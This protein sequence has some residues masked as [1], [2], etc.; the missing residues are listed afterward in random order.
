VIP[1][2][3]DTSAVVPMPRDNQWAREHGLDKSFVVMHSGNVGHS[4]NLGALVR[5]STLLRD[6]DD[7]TIAIIGTGA[8]HA[9][10]VEQ[11]Q[12]LGADAVRFFA[13][14]P[15]AIVSQSLSAADVHYVGLGPGLAG[16]VVPSRVYGI[17]AVGRPV[18]VSAD[19]ES[20]TARLVSEVGCGFVLPP[21]RPD[22]L[23]RLIRELRGGI[24]DLQGM[25]E[26]GRRYVLEKG[27]RTVA[28]ERYRSLLSEVIGR[29]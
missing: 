9:A 18:I 8:R 13:Y 10:L 15:R 11:T 26:L 3:V 1:N 22:M 17:L 29:S 28:I 19:A 5:A 4:Q 24:H 21:S 14:Q 16:Y 27:D 20:E 23:A 6:L 25:G 12:R 7:L 2:W